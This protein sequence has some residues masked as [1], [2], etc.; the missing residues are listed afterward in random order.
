MRIERSRA[1][2]AEAR[3]DAQMYENAPAAER[4][5]ARAVAEGP[6]DTRLSRR[7]R[8]G[9]ANESGSDR[10]AAVRQF[11]AGGDRAAQNEGRARGNGA[12]APSA[13]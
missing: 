11:P 8:K 2:A 6:L 13:K 3:T 7:V 12:D 5:T 1:M 10:W 4:E 9:L